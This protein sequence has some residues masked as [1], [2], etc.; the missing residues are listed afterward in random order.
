MK[1][2]YLLLFFFL[3]SLINYNNFEP[4]QAF[5]KT[6]NMTF[7]DAVGIY[8]TVPIGSDYVIKWSFSGDNILIGVH[9]G[10]MDKSDYD[11]WEFGSIT[12]EVSDGTEIDDSGKFHIP[13]EAI[14]YF[15]IYVT[16]IDALIDTTNVHVV[17]NFELD[18]NLPMILGLSIGIPLSLIIIIV[19]IIIFAVILPKRK[20][21]KQMDSSNILPK[22]LPM[23]NSQIIYCWKCGSENSSENSFCGKCG[24]KLVTSKR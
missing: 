5:E 3:L 12:Y 10:I 20:R 21:M 16:D 7:G 8:H 6:Y 17:V 18:N 2:G 4:V 19:I 1:K 13:Y 24:E 14:W 22:S 9:A 15:V 11:D 23:I